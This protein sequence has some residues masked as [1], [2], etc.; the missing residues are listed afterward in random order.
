MAWNSAEKDSAWK[1]PFLHPARHTAKPYNE[2]RPPGIA[3]GGSYLY[4]NCSMGSASIQ[5]S[6][7]LMVIILQNSDLDKISNKSIRFTEGYNVL[8]STGSYTVLED[9]YIQSRNASEEISTTNPVVRVLIN[10]TTV[11]ENTGIS[12]TYKYFT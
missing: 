5:N 2:N 9:G 6:A 11:I 7:V 10:N 12:G 1:L 4:L 3:S 8:T